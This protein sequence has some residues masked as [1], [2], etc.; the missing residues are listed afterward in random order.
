MLRE[1][2]LEVKSGQNCQAGH[3]LQVEMS[4]KCRSLWREAHLE[5]NML[6]PPHARTT[7]GRPDVVQMLKKCTPLWREAH[8]QVQSVK[9]WGF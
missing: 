5:V 6:K 8:L 7:F 3:L 9:N 2:N 1:A 4:K